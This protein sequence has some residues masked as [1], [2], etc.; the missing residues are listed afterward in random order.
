MADE[1]ADDAPHVTKPDRSSRARH[2]PAFTGRLGRL[3]VSDADIDD[4]LVER[5]A[6][7]LEDLPAPIPPRG[8]PEGHAVELPGRGT[9]WV[10]HA[11]GPEGA[12]TLILLHG[13]TATG[14]LNW[15][16]CFDEL[17]TRFD[18]V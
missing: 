2:R 18:V 15:F 8:L 6:V 17:S 13:W 7:P 16:A 11:P 14:G 5:A 4:P 9:T 1:T 10:H 12:P 3:K